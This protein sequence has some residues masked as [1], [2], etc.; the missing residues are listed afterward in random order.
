ML[1]GTSTVSWTAANMLTHGGPT[2]L[3]TGTGATPAMSAVFARRANYQ[4]VGLAYT[5]EFSPDLSTWQ[6]SASI[7][8][9]L[10][11]DS[12]MQVVSVPFPPPPVTGKP[13]K[14]FRVRISN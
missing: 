2:A 13:S 1:S 12:E 3:Q 9:V 14:F 6:L 7:P 4:A 5:V 10:A 8:M 11:S